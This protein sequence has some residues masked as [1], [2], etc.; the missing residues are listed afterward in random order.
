MCP[1]CGVTLQHNCRVDEI[2]SGC[3]AKTAESNA[4]GPPKYTPTIIGASCYDLDVRL[5]EVKRTR[6]CRAP[7]AAEDTT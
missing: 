1:V 3:T 4:K 7:S 5:Y 6:S 2:V